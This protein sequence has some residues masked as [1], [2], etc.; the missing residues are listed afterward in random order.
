MLQQPISS[1]VFVG[2]RAELEALGERLRAAGQGHGSTVLLSGEAGIGKSRL[3]AEVSSRAERVLR[4]HCFETDS[5][6]PFAPVVDLLRACLS[7]MPP[8]EA[9]TLVAPHHAEIARLLP[10]MAA[11]WSIASRPGN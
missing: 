10:E 11:S 4:G 7:S 1:S 2:R 8:D 9:A 3:V 6:L 5:T